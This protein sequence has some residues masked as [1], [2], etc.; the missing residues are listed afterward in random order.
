[1][2]HQILIT[3]SIRCPEHPRFKRDLSIQRRKDDPWHI[4]QQF[5][6]GIILIIHSCLHV[7]I[8]LHEWNDLQ[9]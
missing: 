1:M 6:S 4:S 9:D 7:E 3:Y 8:G 2:N 5:G